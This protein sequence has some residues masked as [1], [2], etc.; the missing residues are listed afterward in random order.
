MQKQRTLFLIISLGV[1][2]VLSFSLAFFTGEQPKPEIDRDYFRM[3]DT[4]KMDEV[5]LH[6]TLGDVE[7]KF[8][9]N[10]WRVNGQWDADAQMIKVLFATLKQIEPRRPVASAIRDSVSQRLTK[11]GIHVAISEAG[12]KRLS[13]LA[14]GNEDKTE[15]WFLKEGDTQPYVMTLPGYRVYAAG[16]FELEG[17]GWRSKRIFD[18]NWRNFRSL[19]VTYPN[20][21]KQNFE[22]E[23]QDNFFGIKNM[24]QVDTTKLNNFLDAVSLLLADQFVESARPGI[25]SLAALPAAARFEIKDVANRTYSLDVLQ[26]GRKDRQI[27]GRMG[28]GEIVTIGKS[29]ID[30]IVRRRD[31]FLP[32]K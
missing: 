18:F 31:H 15:T 14:G 28:N 5:K 16:I 2:T 21:S 26:P 29:K 10:R 13:F 9:N 30:E 25:D 6:S 27:Y 22:V 20:E 24:S 1:L 32:G 3:M 23:M 11:K 17:N 8:E 12:E 4:E 7:L 19:A